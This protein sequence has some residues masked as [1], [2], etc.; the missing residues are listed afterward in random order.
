MR[1]ET[2]SEAPPE[3][4]WELLSRPERWRE[5]AP[6][7]RGADGLGEPEVRAGARGSV[8]LLGAPV[9][10]RV[11]AVVRGR[12]WAWTVG[13]MTIEHHVAPEGPGSLIAFELIAPG[14]LG[15]PL[16][17]TYGPVVALI[18]RN[19]ARVAASQSG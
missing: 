12:M 11:T 2:Q 9:P 13:P 14:A 17:V 19:L 8:S 1:Y 3:I 16:R 4:V 7:V 15:L 10:V 5:W 6:H 18:A